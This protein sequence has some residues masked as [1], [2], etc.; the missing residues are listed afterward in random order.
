MNRSAALNLPSESPWLALSIGNSRHHWGAFYGQRLQATW[1]IPNAQIPAE[2]AT[3][4]TQL[5]QQL[6]ALPGW[7]STVQLGINLPPLWLASVVLHHPWSGYPQLHQVSLETIPLGNTYPS[8]GVDRA[9]A[10]WGAGL[11]YG[12]PVLVIDGGTALTIS[13]ANAAAQFCGGAILPGLGLQFRALAQG[14]AALPQLDPDRLE[15]P[16][17]WGMDTPSAIYSGI[18]YTMLAGVRDFIDHWH[19]QYPESAILFTGGDGE[20]LLKVL[21]GSGATADPSNSK[22]MAKLSFDPDLVF[23]G[24]AALTQSLA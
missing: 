17:H 6:Q 20:Y 10:V 8:L 22:Q 15:L 5:A 21:N 12:F 1:D 14:T 24:I 23:A 3:E 11:T 19:Q 7:P 4:P 13:S 18:L 9:L 16:P 2:L